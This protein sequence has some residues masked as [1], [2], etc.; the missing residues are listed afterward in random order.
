MTVHLFVATSSPECANFALKTTASQRLK[1]VSSVKQAK[2]L[3][4]STKSLCQKGGFHLH[5]FTSNNSKVLDSVPPEDQATDKRSPNLVSNDPA[6]ERV[7]GVHWCIE[8]D[9][10]QF[11]IELKDK[12]LSRRGILSTVSSIYDPLGLVA[13][14]ILQGKRILQEL[15][16]D[17]VGWDDKVPEDIR[18]R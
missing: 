5:K 2:S 1:S 11:Q 7:L 17:G 10:L 18:P 16:R 6:I 8:T 4:S 3:V 15:C 13:P 12:P 9:T 14:V